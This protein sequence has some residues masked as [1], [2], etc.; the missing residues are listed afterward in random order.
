M[1]LWIEVLQQKREIGKRDSS[2]ACKTFLA[3]HSGFQ[4]TCEGSMNSVTGGLGRAAC[5]P[6]L[7][8]TVLGLVK[9]YLQGPS[10]LPPP[11]LVN[12]SSTSI[13]GVGLFFP[14]LI[15]EGC[16]RTSAP[17][18]RNPPQSPAP[19]YSNPLVDAAFLSPQHSL[20]VSTRTCR[21]QMHPFPG[22]VLLPWQVKLFLAYPSLS[23][24]VFFFPCSFSSWGFS[25]LSTPAK[26]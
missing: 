20:F 24:A 6:E 12:W 11:S 14:H 15:L 23:Q 25:L 2:W 8:S 21:E 1:I 10:G 16:S 17:A 13:R 5:M 19:I 26:T 3:G 18:A 9:A 4:V 7:A 22:L